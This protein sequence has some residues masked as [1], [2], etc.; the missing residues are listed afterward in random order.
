MHDISR[1]VGIIITTDTETMLKYFLFE[2]VR[3]VSKGVVS[4][5]NFFN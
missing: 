1:I 5:K 2:S 4:K 3:A